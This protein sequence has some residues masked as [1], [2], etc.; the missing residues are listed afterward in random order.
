MPIPWKKLLSAILLEM[1]FGKKNLLVMPISSSNGR[2][3]LGSK[4]SSK[5]SL[6]L[7]ALLLQQQQLRKGRKRIEEE[8]DRRRKNRQG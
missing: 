8:E 2:A 3:K 7:P 1:F 6:P 5:V 4:E